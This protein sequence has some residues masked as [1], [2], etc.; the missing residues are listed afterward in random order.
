MASFIVILPILEPAAL[1]P[2]SMAVDRL[3]PLPTCYLF[4][5]WFLGPIFPILCRLGPIFLT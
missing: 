1:L 2:K 5:G 4:L 3:K